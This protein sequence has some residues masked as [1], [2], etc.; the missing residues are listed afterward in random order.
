MPDAPGLETLLYCF[1]LLPWI[2]LHR[3]AAFIHDNPFRH[4]A[5][6]DPEH[7]HVGVAVVDE[8]MD[9]AAG[10]H[11]RAAAGE[12]IALAFD[13][14]GGRAVDDAD[15]FVEVMEVSGQSAAGM[16]QAV[17]TAHF[18]RRPQVRVI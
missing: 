8:I 9:A 17:A 13:D 15:R 14:A 6:V 12:G 16:K 11:G 4:G 7:G 18:D 2:P 10:D 1:S 3:R 5:G